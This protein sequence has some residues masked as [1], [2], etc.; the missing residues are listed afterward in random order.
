MFP[1]VDSEYFDILAGIQG[2]TSDALHEGGW[3]SFDAPTLTLLIETTKEIL[4]EI[5]VLPDD[6]KK[7]NQPYSN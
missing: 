5:Y 4:Y 1:N 3:D 6:K 7:K 2:M